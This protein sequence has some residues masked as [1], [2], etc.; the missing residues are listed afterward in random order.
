[1]APVPDF[2]YVGLEPIPARELGVIGAALVLGAGLALVTRSLAL[3]TQHA[4]LTGAASAVA[5]G[6]ALEG[7]RGSAPA[8]GSVRM[9]IVPWGVLVHTEDTPRILRWAAVKRV[10]LVTPVGLLLTRSVSS[11]VIVET[12]RDRFVGAAIGAAPLDRLVVHLEAYAAEQAT[13]IALDLGGE[14]PADALEP[15]CEALLSATR[16]WLETAEAAAWLEL[17]PAGYRRAST[18]ATSPRAVEV[19]RRVLTDRTPR[20]ADSRAFAAV[21]AAE[22]RA[23]DLAP[24]LIALTQC[25]HPVVAGVAK[26][27]AHRLGA[28]RSRIGTIDELAPFL[29]ERDRA[30]LEAWGRAQA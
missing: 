14:L 22:I 7:A 11:R 26:Q 2:R 30:C 24:E 6:L 5:A 3:D 25:P 28:A 10:E 27:A 17:P 4:L 20:A 9:G 21:I 18:L 19:L 8:S 12:D 1:M 23:T 13:P 29:F 15:E 16:S